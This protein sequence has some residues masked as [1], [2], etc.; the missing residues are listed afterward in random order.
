MNMSEHTNKKYSLGVDIGGTH[1]SA[2]L[3]YTD[4]NELVKETVKNN[5]VEANADKDSILNEWISLIKDSIESL[6]DYTLS[7]IGIAMPG[8]F[9]YKN[10]ICLM[11]GVH[12]Y[13]ALYGLNVKE[14]FRKKLK[15]KNELPI[16]F[17]N[18]AACFALGESLSNTEHADKII[19][20]TLGTGFGAA[21]IQ[22]N[23]IVKEGNN[24]PL[25]GELYN[26]PYL[27][28]ICEDY[29]SARWILG[30]YN[31]QTQNKDESVYAI[32][33][34]A[35]DD[36]DPTAI[37][38]F[39]EFGK[40]LAACLTK[41]ILSFEA[42]CLIIGGGIAKSLSLFL[43]ALKEQ[44][45]Q[46]NALIS[47]KISEAMELSSIK[48]AASLVSNFHSNKNIQSKSW[49][50]SLQPIMPLHQIKTTKPGE[51]NIYP[52]FN[53]GENKIFTSYDSLAEWMMTKN[54]IMIDGI[55]GNDWNAIQTQLSNYFKKKNVS[56]DWYNTDAFKRSPEEIEILI[57]PFISEPGDVWGKRTDL[58]LSD[59]YHTDALSQFQPNKKTALHIL[60]GC[61]AAFANWQNLVYVDLPKNEI[62]YRMRAG[63][64]VSISNTNA[65]SNPEIYKRLYFVD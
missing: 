58:S 27:D 5:R 11:Q 37:K 63:H 23:K 41:W 12:K 32:A 42:D 26:I 60:I 3:V 1:I 31:K 61:G 20:V 62:Q 57:K 10:G 29:V 47:I 50:K 52:S 36:N 48:G 45:K 28:G 49:R 54:H 51:Y 18:D 30:T 14:I 8:P 64:Q 24:V 65:L 35:I 6:K 4:T 56:V 53:I 9:D 2:G 55:A 7:G 13:N 17:E 39:H 19:A 34:K 16:L 22:N 33:R 43:P 21:F 59:F 46:S 15:L 44:L 25:N 40:H 38:I